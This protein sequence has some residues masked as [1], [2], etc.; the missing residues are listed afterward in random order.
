MVVGRIGRK[1]AERGSE[2]MEVVSGMEAA[3]IVKGGATFRVLERKWSW[4]LEG[5]GLVSIA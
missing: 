1:G 3:N 5:V 4:L 2:Q